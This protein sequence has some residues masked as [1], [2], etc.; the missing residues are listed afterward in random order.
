[1]GGNEDCLGNLDGLLNDGRWDIK[2]CLML[3]MTK[4]PKFCKRG[5]CQGSID[6]VDVFYTLMVRN[7][8]HF[9]LDGVGPVDN[10][11]STD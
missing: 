10:R 9:K 1:M 11:P 5:I 4:V 3:N 8:T 2:Y 7:V 6:M